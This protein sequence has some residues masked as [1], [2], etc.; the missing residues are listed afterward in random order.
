M[1][2]EF[3]KE[4]TVLLTGH[5]GFKG[6]WLTLW[7]KKMGAKI[8]GFSNDIPTTPSLF[9]LADVKNGINSIEG[10]IRNFDEVSNVIKKTN[11]EIIF[12]MAAQSL[13]RMSYTNPRETYETNVMGT[14]NLFDALRENKKTRLIINV[15]SDKC[16]DNKEFDRGYTE[17]DA[18]GGYDPYSSSKGC[19]ELVTT[20]FRNSF[21]QSD[22]H[23]I[24]LAS[25]RAGNVI[26]G[27]DWAK[28]RLIP[29]LMQSL[30]NNKEVKIR[31]LHAVRPWQH[32]F[33][34]LSGYLLLA[35]KMWL[36][37]PR[38][39][40]AWNFGPNEQGKKVSWII[41]KI[42]EIYGKKCKISLE[43]SE[44]PHE[45]KTLKLDCTKSQTI[46]GW[47]PKIDIEKMLQLTVDW[48]KE[49]KKQSD[50]KQISEKQIDDFD[51]M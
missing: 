25:V 19:S 14:V 16:Y 22:N 21:F 38:F 51:S 11:P 44:N 29:D 9:E 31:N 12:H 20:A 49:Y 33:E 28:D 43:K 27:G 30:L 50:M 18:L 8:T 17:E 42:S 24:A 34:P 41:D 5:T 13:V 39:A 6:S 46:L 26:G 4:K 36:D 47:K 40:Q 37:G 3:W 1:N 2:K 45:A 7:L 10:D 32:V 23:K 35:E 15:T 48:Y